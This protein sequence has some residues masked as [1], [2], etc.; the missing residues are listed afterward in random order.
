MPE[1]ILEVC[2]LNKQYTN[3]ALKNV[4]FDLK[5]GTI[6]GFIGRNGAGKTTTLKCIYNL[7]HS[8]SGDILYQGEKF[9][10]VEVKAKNEIGLLFGGVDFYPNQKAKTIAKVTATFYDSWDQELYLKLLKFF[11]LNQEKKI[12]QLSNG[13]KVKFGLTLALSHGAKVLLLDEPTSGLDPVSR[14]E[15][16]DCFMKICELKKTTI[17]FSTH[18]ISDLDKCADEIIYIKQGEIY[19]NSTV[20]KFKSDYLHIEGSADSLNGINKDNIGRL[21]IHQGKFS[22]IILKKQQND[23]AQFALREPTLEELML[24][25]ERGHENEETPF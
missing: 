14:D 10:S 7:V 1:T 16:L 18:V 2:N 25:I 17:L 15:V 20:S 23:F 12:K 3:F 21:F 6:Y 22:G 8:D 4:S 5:E 11:D 24:Y 19:Q 13:M 9:Q